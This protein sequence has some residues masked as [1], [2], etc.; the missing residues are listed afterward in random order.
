[1][2]SEGFS[3]ERGPEDRLVARLRCS[4]RQPLTQRTS[5]ASRSSSELVVEI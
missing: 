2:K 5:C 1:M 4:D 3:G